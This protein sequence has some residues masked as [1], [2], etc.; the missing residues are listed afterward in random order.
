MELKN[1]VDIF[2]DFFTDGSTI[3][4]EEQEWGR[5]KRERGGAT[6]KRGLQK[7]GS[8]L[9][10]TNVLLSSCDFV[11]FLGLHYGLTFITIERK[12]VPGWFMLEREF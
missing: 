10:P 8:K 12:F 4:N 2:K 11:V 1:A 9:L 7:K 5:M 6:Q 3:S